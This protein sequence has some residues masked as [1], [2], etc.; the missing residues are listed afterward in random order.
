MK[1]NHRPESRLQRQTGLKKGPHP[2]LSEWDPWDNW[3]IK[4]LLT[5]SIL[6]ERQPEK[7]LVF[8]NKNLQ[9]FRLNH[10]W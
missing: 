6:N 5:D 7:Q 9:I 4:S 3:V 2:N 10:Y 1:T 8:K